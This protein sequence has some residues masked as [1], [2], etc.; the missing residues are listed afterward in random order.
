VGTDNVPVD[1][2][3]PALVDRAEAIDEEVVADVV[4]AVAL[5]V[6]ELDRLERRG[7]RPG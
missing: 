5:D 1:P 2:S 4:P 7:A 6:V 3:V